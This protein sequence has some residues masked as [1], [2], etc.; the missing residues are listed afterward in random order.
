MYVPGAAQSGARPLAWAPMEGGA[1][2][3][4]LRAASQSAQS[5]QSGHHEPETER[6]HPPLDGET[7]R[8][9]PG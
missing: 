8:R 4:P 5:G 1:P 3:A 9:Q 2:A 7:P 6:D